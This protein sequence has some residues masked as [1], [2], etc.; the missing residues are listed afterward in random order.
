[1]W[2]RVTV[3]YGIGIT[4]IVPVYNV[5]LYLEE[6]LDSVLCQTFRN[7]EIICVE[8]G[9]TDNSKA[10]LQKYEQEY[11]EIHVIYHSVNKGLSEA[12][13]TGMEAARGKYILF[14]DSDDLFSCRNMLEELWQLG[15]NY[16]LDIIY[17]DMI[18]KFGDITIEEKQVLALEENEEGKQI[19]SGQDM[20]CKFAQVRDYKTEACRQFFRRT[21]LRDKKIRFYEGILH[22][23]NL[24]SFLCLMEAERVMN[25]KKTYYIY[26]QRDNSIMAVQNG[27]RTRSLFVVLTEIYFYWNSHKLSEQV[28]NAVAVY[29]EQLYRIYKRY[30]NFQEN[31][32][33]MNCGSYASNFIYNLMKNHNRPLLNA[34]QLAQISGF[35]RVIVYGAGPIATD[36]IYFLRT[37]QIKIECIAVTKIEGNPKEL[38]SIEV[39]EIT[40]L[41]SHQRDT[42]VILGV[43]M[44]HVEEIISYL[45]SLGFST[46]ITSLGCVE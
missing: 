18:K 42:A 27:R 11:E 6:C 1:M 8:D 34:E 38:F 14:L 7:Y 21:F 43:K 30:C 35:D 31:A 33:E 37:Y 3:G 29:F 15:E 17:F 10:I 25:I 45:K 41:L 40:E 28:N 39:K 22:E 16:T 12:R 13:N 20:L 23:D 36:L 9:S 26:R 46:I 4:V 32:D 19:Y 24:F 44:R 5:E 2:E